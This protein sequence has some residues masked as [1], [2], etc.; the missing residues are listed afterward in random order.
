MAA[1]WRRGGVSR[2]NAAAPY[3]RTALRWAG[4]LWLQVS[5]EDGRPPQPMV[6]DWVQARPTRSRI[7]LKMYMSP[8]GLRQEAVRVQ[9]NCEANQW[10]GPVEGVEVS[11]NFVAVEIE[12][13]P[14]REHLAGVG[15]NLRGW[16]NVWARRGNR[17]VD[18]AMVWR[19]AMPRRAG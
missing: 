18:Y 12:H 10:I 17:G 9:W 19:E 8:P 1:P 11:D 4:S 13:L 2:H 6:G 14:T 5:T 15:S 16:I 3:R 7:E